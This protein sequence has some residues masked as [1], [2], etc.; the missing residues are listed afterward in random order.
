MRRAGLTFLATATVAALAFACGGSKPPPPP[1]AGLDAA[2]EVLLDAEVVADAEAPKPDTGSVVNPPDAGAVVEEDAGFDPGLTRRDAGLAY[3]AGP[4][5][6]AV[7]DIVPN[8]RLYGYPKGNATDPANTWRE[9][10]LAQFWDPEG[11]QGP[12]GTARKTLFVNVSARWC[13]YCKLEAATQDETCKAKAG[14]GL[15]CYTSL[16]QN[17]SGGPATRDDINYW[18]TTYGLELPITVDPGFQWGIF[19]SEEGT[20]LNLFVDLKTMRIAGYCLGA[21][22][23]CIAQSLDD[24]T[25]CPTAVCPQ[26]QVCRADGTCGP[27]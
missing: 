9:L 6:T 25:R 22:E 17:S 24:F 26:G 21:D 2:A 7:G 16:F 14:Q 12:N 20:P 13:S 8:I 4:F 27:K 19:F 3:P 1:V 5:G 10:S 18:M 11:N 15:V 23:Q